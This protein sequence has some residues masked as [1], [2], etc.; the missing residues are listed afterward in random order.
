MLVDGFAPSRKLRRRAY[1]CVIVQLGGTVQFHVQSPQEKFPRRY[2]EGLWMGKTDEHTVVTPGNKQLVRTAKQRPENKMVTKLYS[3][4]WLV[5]HQN[6]NSVCHHS[7][8][9]TA[10]VP[11][12][13]RVQQSD[14]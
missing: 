13:K 11:N 7:A 4:L 10:G 8:S 12:A 5:R 3:R 6:Q 2:E 9:T 1:G 14:V